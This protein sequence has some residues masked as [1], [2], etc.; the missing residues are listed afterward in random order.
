[1]GFIIIRTVYDTVTKMASINHSDP[2]DCEKL[3]G[4]RVQRDGYVGVRRRKRENYRWYQY[5]IIIIA[6]IKTRY[7]NT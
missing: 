5:Y 1:M 2:W 4:R 7:Y 6:S 3:D